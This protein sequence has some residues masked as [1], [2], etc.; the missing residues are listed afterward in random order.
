[1]QE[2][3]ERVTFRWTRKGVCAVTGAEN[4]VVSNGRLGF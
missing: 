2:M 3:R 4:W 1:M